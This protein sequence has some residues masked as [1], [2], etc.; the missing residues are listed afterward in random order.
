[1]KNQV[2]KI[3]S[4]AVALRKI[5][6][7]IYARYSDDKLQRDSS[8]EDQIRECVEKAASMGCEIPAENIYTDAGSRG[9]DHYRPRFLSMLELIESERATFKIL[10]TADMSRPSRDKEMSE[11]FLK[12]LKTYKIRLVS[13]EDGLD[14][15]QPGFEVQFMLKTW[16]AAGNAQETG[17]RVRRGAE[18]RFLKGNVA[19]GRTYGYDHAYEYDDTRRGP[20]GSRFVS[21]VSYVINQEKAEVIVLIYELYC[22]GLGYS[23]IAKELNMRKSRPPRD[24]SKSLISGWNWS[25]VRH[26]LNNSRY[27]GRPV[28]NKTET[29]RRRKG[30]IRHRP[31][32]ESEWLRSD[33]FPEQQIVSD[34]LWEAA[35]RANDSR[36]YR[37]P[38]KGAQSIGGSMRT[39]ASRRYL[40]SGMCICGACGTGSMRLF[41]GPEGYYHC[42]NYRR[43]LGCTN[44]LRIKRT[45][46]EHALVDEMVAALRIDFTTEDV[47]ALAVEETRKEIRRL[48]ALE[49]K[50]SDRSE[51]LKRQATLQSK[52]DRLGA[53]IEEV[54]GSTTLSG[55]LV[56][57]EAELEDVNAQLSAKPRLIK[58]FSDAEI[59][60]EVKQAF[61]SLAEVILGDP[62]AARQEL[63]A[64]VKRLI[65][66]PTT[67]NGVPAYRVTG[68][69]RLFPENRPV[70]LRC[71]G[72]KT[73]ELHNLVLR[74]DGT[75]LRMNERSEV[76]GV[77]RQYKVVS[78]TAQPT[79]LEPVVL[80]MSVA[81][82]DDGDDEGLAFTYELCEQLLPGSAAAWG[83]SAQVN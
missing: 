59:R 16:Q 36:Q 42:D 47:T 2:A 3:N 40:F 7:A 82:T 5:E 29:Y 79:D 31:T 18:G 74:L 80:T 15:D 4:A 50:T 65:L 41:N 9:A 73:S 1:M 60:Q 28:R 11:R 22:G 66:T 51:L 81:L 30:E 24:A 64:R 63:L 52:L 77:H 55:R 49:S 46:L 13:V 75:V 27:I 48:K 8:I 23:L 26:I 43:G 6:G 12:A 70:V 35:R 76:M 34:Q 54:G 57:A 67:D 17:D 39:A 78:L 19:S 25:A 44:Q 69:L 20:H 68:D 53:T 21:A 71:I 62:Q 38:G 32:P 10:Y 83:F 45:D 58:E 56:R 14:S 72:P 37:G 61:E 33:Y